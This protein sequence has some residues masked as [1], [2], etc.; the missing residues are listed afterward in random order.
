MWDKVSRFHNLNR[1]CRNNVWL[2]RLCVGHVFVSSNAASPSDKL[3]EYI[4]AVYCEANCKEH[5]VFNC[6]YVKAESKFSHLSHASP[7]LIICG[8]HGNSMITTPA[9]PRY[10]NS[11]LFPFVDSQRIY[12]NKHLPVLYDCSVRPYSWTSALLYDIPQRRWYEFNI[13]KPI[14]DEEWIEV[15]TA[16]HLELH[17]EPFNT[18]NFD[19][20]GNVVYSIKENVGRPIRGLPEYQGQVFQTAH[21][22][23]VC[24]KQYLFRAVDTC[25]WQGVKCVYKQIE[26]TENIEAMQREIASR[27]ALLEFYGSKDVSALTNHGVSPILAVV[28]DQ[29][30]P[31]ILGILM[32]YVGKS[33]DALINKPVNGDPLITM[34]H[35]IALVR[36]VNF[37]HSAGII[38]GDI[39]ERNVCVNETTWIEPIQLIDFGE[40]APEYRGDIEACG[41][42]LRWCANVVVTLTED[43]KL[44]I[45]Y[46]AQS[47]L[48]CRDLREAMR[49]LQYH[50]DEARC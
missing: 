30:P 32:P 31:L 25:V 27:E 44:R 34:T 7:S 35:I 29:E 20:Q 39:C 26:F 24:D 50:S 43:E 22:K 13:S 16:H 38:H 19:S 3:C 11:F 40:V 14:D 18:I 47:L 10:P 8:R 9:G 41:L 46:A 49:R 21:I 37:I 4:H 6:A 5:P 17:S 23:D 1:G 45:N 42:L 2:G 15:T 48:I 33:L 36:A 28:V 12:D